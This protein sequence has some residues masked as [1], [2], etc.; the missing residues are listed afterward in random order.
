MSR[1]QGEKSVHLSY[2]VN[3]LFCLGKTN[4]ESISSKI[5]YIYKKLTKIRLRSQILYTIAFIFL[6]F[7]KKG[8]NPIYN[9]LLTL[10][11][12]GLLL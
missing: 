11:L 12:Q 9:V 3:V 5:R 10:D 2:K 7:L 8:I 6:M 4:E 1:F